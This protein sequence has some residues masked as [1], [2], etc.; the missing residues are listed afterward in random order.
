MGNWIIAERMYQHDPEAML[1]MR[2]RTVIA[3]IMPA[4]RGL[5]ADQPSTA[6]SSFASEVSTGTAPGLPAGRK[7]TDLLKAPGVPGGR[8]LGQAG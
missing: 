8:V 2:P 5:P 6:S 7:L 1:N 3:P 4:G